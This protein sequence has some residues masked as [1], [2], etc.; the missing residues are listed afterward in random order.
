MK[1]VNVEP[2][3]YSYLLDEVAACGLS[4]SA[5][6]R[7]RLGIQATTGAGERVEASELDEVLN[8]SEFRYAKGVVGRF[9]VLL[10]WLHQRN[11]A[12]FERVENIRGRGRL[13]FAKSAEVLEAAGHNVNPKQIPRSPFW[14]ITTSPTI[15][16]QEMIGNVM[17]VLNHSD[18]EIRRAQT[19]IAGK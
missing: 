6:L 18:S 2:D 8:S 7:Q 10:G 4:I 14:V 13:Y 16:K 15:L 5:L 19:A 1:P 12:E 17:K 9:L 11:P 3:V